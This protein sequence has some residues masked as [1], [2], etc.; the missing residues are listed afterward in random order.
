MQQYKENS[1]LH[2][3]S[4]FAHVN[5]PLCCIVYTLPVLK[6]REKIA[7]TVLKILDITIK[8]SCLGNW[9]PQICAPLHDVKKQDQLFFLSPSPR[10]FVRVG[11]VVREPCLL[12][13]GCYVFW[14]WA[15]SAIYMT[16]LH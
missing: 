8:F 10:P 2:C 14:L 12:P 15:C 6:L 9:A 16:H 1:L 7:V 4:N 13:A 5:M 3:H 11:G